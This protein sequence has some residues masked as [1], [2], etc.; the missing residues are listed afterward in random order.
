[1]KKHVALICSILLAA[2][3]GIAT[4]LLYSH[5]GFGAAGAL[6]LGSILA[7]FV[8][9]FIGGR[10]RIPLVLVAV[11][12]PL[13]V[14]TYDN[15]LFYRENLAAGDALRQIVQ[16]FALALGVL[17]ALPVLVVFVVS[18]FIRPDQATIPS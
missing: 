12:P 8:F 6:I 17:V 3:L 7:T 13:A 11:L 2:G 18:R 9:S 15:Y 1:M 14:S 10:L 16:P 5:S 4:T